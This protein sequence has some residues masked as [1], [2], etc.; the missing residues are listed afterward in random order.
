MISKTEFLQ[1]VQRS[2]DGSQVVATLGPEGTSSQKAAEHLTCFL[3]AKIELF[4]TY[5]MA[6][7]SLD[8]DP[9]NRALL[10]ANAYSNINLFYISEKFIPVTAF[11][12]DTP[13]YVLAAR[14][15]EVSKRP[16]IRVAS[17]P[18][19]SHMVSRLIKSEHYQL[20]ETTSTHE[21]ARQTAFGDVD[22]C[23]T[24]EVAASIYNLK[25]IGVVMETI[26]MLWTVF[27]IRNYK[28]GEKWTRKPLSLFQTNFQLA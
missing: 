21:A 20:V 17:H 23:L 14:E 27:I 9:Y 10:T 11:F 24:T 18:A 15:P 25:I 7:A 19:P 2:N 6:A 16:Q 28:V 22:A 12:F 26:P 3:P 4:P 13:S 5:E 1:F 8:D